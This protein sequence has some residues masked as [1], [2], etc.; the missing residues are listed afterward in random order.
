MK[1]NYSVTL[2][3]EVVNKAKSKLDPTQKLSPLIEE[4]LKDWLED[5]Y[6][7]EE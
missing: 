1:R 3:E 7:G 6:T 5:F 2:D 4:L